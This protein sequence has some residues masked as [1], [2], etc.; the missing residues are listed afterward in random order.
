MLNNQFI[1]IHSHHKPLLLNEF[2]IRNA[3]LKTQPYIEAAYHFSCGVHPWHV[4]AYDLLDAKNCLQKLLE[5]PHYLAIGECGLDKLS[6]NWEQQLVFFE[7]QIDLAQQFHK[8]VIVHCVRAYY[9][10]IPFIKKSKTA[11]ILHAYR[12]NALQTTTLLKLPNVFFSFGL[13]RPEKEERISALLKLIPF[14][15]LFFE[16]DTL[17]IGV[18]KVYE[19]FAALLNINITKLKHQVELNFYSLE[20]FF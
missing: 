15:K 10:L 1:N 12:G 4:C 14:E 6:A 3:Y 16:T 11:F 20:H 8:P 19:Q 2:V 18:E 9:E 17:R 5:Q 7:M 13:V